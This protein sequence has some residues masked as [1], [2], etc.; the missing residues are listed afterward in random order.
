MKPEQIFLFG[1]QA[2]QQA[3]KDSDFDLLVIV[4]SSDLMRHQ[5]EAKSYDLLW[6]LATPVDV[7]VLTREEFDR[8]SQVKTSLAA[9]VKT[10]GQLLYHGS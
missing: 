7:I 9:T 8:S 2:R 6:G 10:E 1:S 5:R 4:S 3:D